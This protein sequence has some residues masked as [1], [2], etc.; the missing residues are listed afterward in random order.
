MKPHEPSSSFFSQKLLYLLLA[1]SII[2]NVILITR[3]RFPSL[4]QKLIN[5]FIAPPQVSP[6]DKVR[7][8]ANSKN[9]VIVYTDFQCPFCAQLHNTMNSVI[10]TSD[11]RWIMRHFP[12]Q[13]HPLAAKA[14]EASECSGEQGKFWEY[15]DALYQV[16]ETLVE[17]N[18]LAIAV[19]L[20]LDKR[21]FES[22][23]NSGKFQSH[24][25]GQVQEGKKLR[26]DATPTIFIN[27]KRFLGAMSSKEL[28]KIVGGNDDC[29]SPSKKGNDAEVCK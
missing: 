25:L 4:P 5:A 14:A 9:T 23:L 16:S 28:H 15:S 17:Q 20:G 26:V 19:N 6:T 11:T 24:V 13:K 10:K 22:C 2:T 1:L 18:L 21:K 27:G 29:G 8:N 3:L 7:G 12:S